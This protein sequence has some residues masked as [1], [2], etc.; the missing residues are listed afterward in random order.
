MVSHDG[1]GV[2]G[3]ARKTKARIVTYLQAHPWSTVKAIALHVRRSPGTV[4]R[5]LRELDAEACLWKR[6]C[7]VSQHGYTWEYALVEE[8]T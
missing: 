3:G 5:Y 8:G 2:V 4:S 1:R 7:W 6:P